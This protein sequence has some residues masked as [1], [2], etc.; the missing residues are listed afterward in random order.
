MTPSEAITLLRRQRAGRTY[1][2]DT[3]PDPVEV[4]VDAYRKLA[5]AARE[6][7]WFAWSAVTADCEPARRNLQRKIDNLRAALGDAP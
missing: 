4:L 7:D 1:S 5:K 2:A 6:L 3:P